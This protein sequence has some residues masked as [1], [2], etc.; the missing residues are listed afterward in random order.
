LIDETRRSYDSVAEDFS[1]TRAEFWPELSYLAE[2]ARENARVLDIGCGNGRFY[3]LLKERHVEYTGVDN[4]SKLLELARTAHPSATFMEADATR[5][6]FPDG[7]FDIAF[8][9]ATIHHIPSAKLRKEFVQEASRVLKKGSTFILT[10]WDLWTSKHIRKLLMSYLPFSVL[11]AGDIV[12]PLVKS[13][14]PRYLHA[15][16]LREI[17]RLLEANGFIVSGAEIARRPSGQQNIVVV[18]KKK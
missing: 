8:S 14:S 6:P 16:T 5:L 17:K 9:F 3:P 12:V 4:S 15:F 18:A 2:H 13:S 7:S 10:T 11:D 1:A